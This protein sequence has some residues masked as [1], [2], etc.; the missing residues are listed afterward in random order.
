VESNPA[1]FV[2]FDALV[3]DRCFL[4]ALEEAIKD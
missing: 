4:E 2:A 1:A 3:A